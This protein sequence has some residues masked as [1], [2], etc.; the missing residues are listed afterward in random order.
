MTQCL[1]YE[2]RAKGRSPDADD[3]K[4]GEGAGGSLQCSLVNL[5]GQ[6]LDP[7]NRVPDH[8]CDFIVRGHLGGP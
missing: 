3:E 7:G 2:L 5:V 8:P 6:V 1:A 4:I